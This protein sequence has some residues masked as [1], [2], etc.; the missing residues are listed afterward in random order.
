MK[1]TSFATAVLGCALLTGNASAAVSVTFS[2]SEDYVGRF[3]D[4][5]LYLDRY[6]DGRHRVLGYLGEYF[7]RLGAKLPA[8]Q[9][10]KIEVLNLY[11]LGGASPSATNVVRWPSIRLRYS[12]ESQGQVLKSGEELIKDMAPSC[13]RMPYGEELC[14][15]KQMLNRWFNQTLLT[16]RQK[17]KGST[18][19]GTYLRADSTPITGV[20]HF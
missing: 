6:E 19:E 16:A 4:Y 8:D 15:E 14:A 7:Q 2:N 12:L 17:F 5:G 10:L 9:D 18:S 11:L 13:N 1:S 20:N 3:A